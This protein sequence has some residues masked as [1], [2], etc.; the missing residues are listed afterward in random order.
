MFKSFL[1]TV[2]L[3]NYSVYSLKSK[4]ICI[5]KVECNGKDCNLSICNGK[6][7]YDCSRLECARNEE[8]CDEYHEMVKYLDLKKSSKLDKLKTLGTMR[9]VTFVTKNVRMFENLKKNVKECT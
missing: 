3:L 4:D 6:L 2:F 8:L 1:I 5:K 9:G 7:S